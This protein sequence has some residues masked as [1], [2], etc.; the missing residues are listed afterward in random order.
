MNDIERA[1]MY[2]KAARD[3]CEQAA[4]QSTA[5]LN[6]DQSTAA[7]LNEI[8]HELDSVYT[9]VRLRAERLTA[10]EILTDD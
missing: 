3:N 7:L 9:I 4:Q 8:T 6:I 10:A 1:V 5:S 2:L